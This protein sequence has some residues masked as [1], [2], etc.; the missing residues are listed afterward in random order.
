VIPLRRHQQLKNTG[1]WAATLFDMTRLSRSVTE[2]RLTK[3]G[4]AWYPSPA[5]RA[6]LEGAALSN[7]GAQEGVFAAEPD[8]VEVADD[9]AVGLPERGAGVGD[10][11]GCA[12]AGDERLRF[13]VGKGAPWTGTGGARSDS[14][15]HP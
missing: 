3:L 5:S 2:A 10:A 9:D 11:L 13:T 15:A 6:G 4:P 1:Q 8:G 12:V 7:H 14:S